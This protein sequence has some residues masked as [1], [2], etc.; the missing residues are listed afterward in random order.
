MK[1][2]LL[3]SFALIL[4]GHSFSQDFSL[5]YAPMEETDYMVIRDLIETRDKHLIVGFDHHNASDMPTA[6][7]MKTAF[8]GTVI[9]AKTLDVAESVAGCTFEVA[10]K[11]NGNL[12]LWGLSKEAETNHMR[13]ILSELD[14]NGEELWSKEYDFGTNETVAYTINKMTVN[15]DGSLS[16]M[17]AIY[18]RVIVMKTTA[19]GEIIWA[20]ASSIGAPDEGGKNPGF[21]WLSI[22]E[23]DG[24]DDDDEDDDGGGACAG[25]ATNDFSLLRYS[26]DGELLWNKAYSLGGY[27]H[28]KTIARAPNGNILVAGFIDYVPHVMEVSEED[29]SLLWVKNF[30]GTTLGYLGKAHLTV[31]DDEILFDLSNPGNKHYILKLSETGEVLEAMQTEYDVVDYNKLEFAENDNIYFYG[32]AE[33]STGSYD[34]MIHRVQDLFSNTCLLRPSEI[35]YTAADFT[36]TAEVDFTPYEED[37]TNQEDIEVTAVDFDLRAK[38][39]CDVVLGSDDL[40][41]EKP[42]IFPNPATELVNIQVNGKISDNAHYQ[43]LDLTGKVIMNGS[44]TSTITHLDLNNVETGQYL[45]YVS[46]VDA[47]SV[48]KLSVR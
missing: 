20:K 38:Y 12:Y 25:K 17:I 43:L 15:N 6:G 37:F 42:I 46:N 44:I 36:D 10:E 30:P 40:S 2:S 4:G 7:I 16:M 31:I 5:D 34:G 23:P 13:A 27:T 11:E 14:E 48:Q 9:W 1:K 29:G 26:A 22:P 21:E 19:T 45:L 3:L 41:F 28:G 47:Q 35:V 32:S 33:F 39:A 8:D 24:D 18:S